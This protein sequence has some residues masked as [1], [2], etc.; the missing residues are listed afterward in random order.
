MTGEEMIHSAARLVEERRKSYGVPT[1]SMAAVAARWSVTLGR[2]VTSAQVV[3]CLIDLKL[4]RLA[5]DPAHLDS[6]RDI[7][8]YAAVLRE[9]VR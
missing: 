8:G 6:A 2:P 1:T 3:L 5:H 7:A 4:A 9:V